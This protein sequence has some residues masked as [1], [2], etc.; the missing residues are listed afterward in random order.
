LINNLIARTSDHQAE[1]I[2]TLDGIIV[3]IGAV[4][5]G[6]YI[7]FTKRKHEVIQSEKYKVLVV[8]L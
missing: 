7:A 8:S 4:D 2:Y 6:H 1:A 5:S 3:H